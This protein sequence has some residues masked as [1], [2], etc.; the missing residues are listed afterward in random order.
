MIR[1]LKQMA[2]R[3]F[4]AHYRRKLA[5][6]HVEIHPSAIINKMP[7]L[8]LA[9]GSRLILHEDVTLTSNGRH[10]PLLLH[11]VTLRTLTPQAVIE[12]MPHSGITGSSIVCANRVTIGEYTVIGANTL[13][14]DS[15]GHTYSEENGWSSPRALT[16]NPISI[17]SK[18]FIGVNCIIMGGVTIGDNCLVSAGTVVTADIPAGHK[19]FG[20]PMQ[21]EP[22]PKALGGSG[23][24]Q[25]DVACAHETDGA[26]PS[27][28]D[29]LAAM[30]DALEFDFEMG[31]DDEFREYEDW[32]S[33]AFLSLSSCMKEDYGVDFNTEV[34][35]KVATWRDIYNLL[36]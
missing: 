31:M 21:I 12:F 3:A 36:P 16:G 10:N 24:E 28:E 30:K 2:F 11:P 4:L 18:C 8:R 5:R 15:F 23:A 25:P 13:I 1:R 7:D 22:L 27:P 19:A 9:K 32:D 34:Y 33:I 14:Y 6:R 20:N 17:G 29:F 35:N 26:K